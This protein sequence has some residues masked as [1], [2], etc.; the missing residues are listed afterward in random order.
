MQEFAG[1][2]APGQHMWGGRQEEELDCDAKQDSS[3]S[4]GKFC[5]LDVPPEFSQIG[6]KGPNFLSPMSPSH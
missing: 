3:R 6:T 1:T 4:Y 2:G 5:S